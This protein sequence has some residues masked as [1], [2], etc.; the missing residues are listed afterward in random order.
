MDAVV[1]LNR[2][3]GAGS[4]GVVY[5]GFDHASGHFVAIKELTYVEP[6][7][8][9]EED[10]ELASILSELAC[11]REAKHPNLVKYC[12]ARRSA[13]GIQIVMEYVSGGSLDYVLKRCGPVRETVARAY[14]RDV[15]EALHYLH[16]TMR[17]CHRDVKPANVL[18]TSDG[19]C[20]LADFGVAKRFGAPSPRHSAHAAS[21][22]QSTAEAEED[23]SQR[24]GDDGR[25]G[26]LQTA[27]GTP[28]YMAPEVINGGVDD[29]DEDTA[30]DDANALASG[31]EFAGNGSS[32]EGW[33]GSGAVHTT[34]HSSTSPPPLY[35]TSHYYNPLKKIVKEGRLG[36]RSVGYTTSADIWSVGVTVYEMVSGTKPF[37]A[38]LS[39]PSAVLFRIANCAAS[40]PQLPAEMHF[41]SELQNFLDLCFVYDKDLRATASELLGHPWLRSLHKGDG[42]VSASAVEQQPRR[43]SHAI[44]LSKGDMCVDEGVPK[45]RLQ[46]PTVRPTVFDGVPLLD[47]IDLPAYP[48]SA[49]A[50]SLAVSS[51]EGGGSG[52]GARRASASPPGCAPQSAHRL[53]CS[54]MHASGSSVPRSSPSIMSLPPLSVSAAE[55][56]EA[57]S[58]YATARQRIGRTRAAHSANAT[59]SAAPPAMQSSS[60]GLWSTSGEFVDIL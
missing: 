52:E 3:L 44:T 28:W 54:S 56:A 40:P 58:R 11:M 47:T 5:E 19:R 16:R 22:R 34:P 17:V 43:L 38:D 49:V 1:K 23:T 13:M 6:S 25:Q 48:A 12:G 33:T 31:G 24:H 60:S 14:T 55:Q 15:L 50:S 46:Q 51:T 8:A 30:L 45:K 59:A 57:S 39:N 41:S 4:R 42:S 26:Y 20:K 36:V 9:A 7:V 35:S 37:G 32:G 29:E 53:S 21:C 10:T 18:I 27:V 2:K